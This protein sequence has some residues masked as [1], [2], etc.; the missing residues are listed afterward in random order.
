VVLDQVRDQLRAGMAELIVAEAPGVVRY[1]SDGVGAMSTI[2]GE[3][4]ESDR[5]IEAALRGRPTMHD[6]DGAVRAMAVPVSIGGRDAALA[7]AKSL[8]DSGGFGEDRLHLLEALANHAGIALMKAN[9]VER[10]KREVSE[11]EYLALYDPLSGLPNRRHFHTLV[12]GLLE[13]AAE[14][15]LAVFVLDIDRFKEM[16]DALGHETGDALLVE[17]AH[18]L[19]EHVAG[20]GVVARMGGDEFAVLLPV[21]SSP[22]PSA[23][24]AADLAAVI[25]GGM[26]LGPLTLHA[27]ASIGVAL[28][29]SHGTDAQ[30]LV[31]HA[32][33]AMYAAK[34]RHAGIQVYDPTTDRNTPQRLARIADLRQA[35]ERGDLLVAFQPK[36]DPASGA[37]VGAE[38]LVR[39]CHP[40]DGLISPEEF[41][42]LAEHSGLIRP[43]TA[44]VLETALRHRAGWERD[45][46]RLGIAVNLSPNSLSDDALLDLVSRLLAQ[47]ATRPSALTLEITEG[48]VMT[49]P[50]SSLATLAKLHALGV[51][52]SIDDFGTG[53]SSLSR[54]RRFPIDEVKID[55]SFVQRLA[56]DQR[57][58]ALV[59]SAIQMG[60]ALDL[61]V[62]AEGVEDAETMDFLAGIG[63]DTVQ[64]F[65][66]SRPLFADD[67]AGW[68]G[69][70]VPA[71]S[72][73]AASPPA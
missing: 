14:T 63:C 29:P 66:I 46:H 50:A 49:D 30:S 41:V 25:E 58:R 69:R 52:L 12:D 61:T 17:I 28:A 51:K 53:Y 6:P 45:G 34:Q 39:W 71:G 13:Q 38:A 43:L 40:S 18:R 11:K 24:E 5:W 23:A 8:P 56:S 48:A 27:R 64:G 47:T 21:E 68:L 9:L 62:V 32:D 35:V 54:L 1:R 65:H 20:R 73:A 19:R 70:H 42:P 22:E 10:L 59:R 26:T 67:F 15:A 36:A 33:V 3:L 72:A 60:H 37:V 16:N 44:H 31:R 2:R 55:R 4:V 57:D 7:V